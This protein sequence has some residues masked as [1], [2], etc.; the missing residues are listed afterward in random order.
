MIHDTQ[1]GS[2]WIHDKPEHPVPGTLNI[3]DDGR[4]ELTTWHAENSFHD[5]F[6]PYF[7]RDDS[8]KTITGV[9]TDGII[10]LVKARPHARNTTMKT[11]LTETQQKWDCDYALQSKTYAPTPLEKNVSSIEM[12][13][14]SLPVWARDEQNLQL[15]WRNRH[16]SWPTKW[17]PNL[18]DS[19]LGKIGVQYSGRLSGLDRKSSYH[20]AQLTIDASFLVHFQEVQDLE[21][22][23]DTVSTLQSLV[24]VAT[25]QPV[26]VEKILLTVTEADES[27]KAVF[28]YSPVLDPVL[29]G[30]KESPLFTFHEIGGAEGVA[31]WTNCLYGQPYVKNGL[32][33]DRYHRPAFITYITQRRLL[34]CE[35]YQRRITNTT[36]GQMPF[37]DTLPPLH[38]CGQAFLEWIGSWDTWKA[39][40]TKIRHNHTAHLQSYARPSEDLSNVHLVNRQLYI[41]LLLRVL[42]ECEFPTELMDSV[43]TRANSQ[44]ISYLA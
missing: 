29:P 44:A 34:A 17:T 6:L 31:K 30:P 8:P 3:N 5:I 11:Y 21:A 42:N 37:E 14:Q 4:L 40:I 33:I 41:Y 35:A 27:N 39:A 10:A 9:T 22:V 38:R 7:E 25:G 16:L 26:A 2:F 32:L 24:S 28:H 18:H 20:S 1:R 36:R 23:L 12:N 13:I 19:S 15:D 43:A